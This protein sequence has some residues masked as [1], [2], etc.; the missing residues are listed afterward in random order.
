MLS[1]LALILQAKK[2]AGTMLATGIGCVV[3]GAAPGLLVPLFTIIKS[4]PTW[5]I[6][7]IAVFISLSVLGAIASIF[8]GK[9]AAASMVGNLA[10]WI[11][12]RIILL[13][14]LPFTALRKFFGGNDST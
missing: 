8:I 7:L 2:L 10:A 5:V 11:I 13:L 12:R 4:L 3:V 1:G 14:I 9:A 6:L